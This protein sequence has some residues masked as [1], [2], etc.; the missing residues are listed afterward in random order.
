MSEMHVPNSDTSAHPLLSIITVT[1]DDPEGLKRTV[2]SVN[3]QS[4]DAL[5]EQLVIDGVSN[6]DV[7][8]LLLELNAPARLISEKDEGLYDAMNKGIREAKG[9]YLFFLNSGDCFD[10]T[11][12][13]QAL[14]DAVRG[15]PADLVYGD[16]RE[17]LEDGTIVYKRARDIRWI[18][19]GMHTHHQAIF[20]RR[21]LGQTHNIDYDLQYRLAADYEY[22]LRY[23]RVAAGVK[24]IDLPVCIF[25]SGGRSQIKYH[26]A[27]VEQ[28]KIREKHFGSKVFARA[29]L[30]AQKLNLLLR[31]RLPAVYWFLKR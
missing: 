22:T 5:C 15:S 11:E 29:V 24:R 19:M 2:E 7:A 26:E 27:H 16:S 14:Q 25:Q 13:I 10:G 31:K 18:G 30:G 1:L 20:Y 21:S 28:A 17:R 12:V 9:D 6:Y 8:G 3:S 23:A 4:G